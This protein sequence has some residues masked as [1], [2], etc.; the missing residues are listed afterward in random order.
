MIQRQFL[1]APILSAILF[2]K[3]EIAVGGGVPV[4]ALEV[5]WLFWNDSTCW[6]IALLVWT[7]LVG[8]LATCIRTV[9]I[10]RGGRAIAAVDPGRSARRGLVAFAAIGLFGSPVVL[11]VS[12]TL[13][14]EWLNQV[15]RAE[16]ISPSP[17][18]S[19]PATAKAAQNGRPLLLQD[20]SFRA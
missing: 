7:V 13:V 1:L 11:A 4:L 20:Q 12:C 9:L 14:K 6:G 10:R 15:P 3:G 2:A 5:G 19:L 16:G 8:S 18:P 17:S